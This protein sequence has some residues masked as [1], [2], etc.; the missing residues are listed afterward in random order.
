MAVLSDCPRLQ[1][2]GWCPTGAVLMDVVLRALQLP[3]SQLLALLHFSVSFSVSL[4]CLGHLGGEQKKQQQAFFVCLFVFSS[5]SGPAQ[6]VFVIA[7]LE[8][9]FLKSPVSL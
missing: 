9:V 3:A 6:F 7:G 8:A 5:P 4:I 1:V 2:A